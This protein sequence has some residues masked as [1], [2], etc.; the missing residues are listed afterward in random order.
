MI[1]AQINE[2][3]EGIR[4]KIYKYL[5]KEVSKKKEQQVKGLV[6]GTCWDL[7]ESQ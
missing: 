4:K 2:R 1:F 7:K 5:E 3:Q 6:I